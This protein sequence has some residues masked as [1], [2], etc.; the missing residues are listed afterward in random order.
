MAHELKKK[1]EKFELNFNS[2]ESQAHELKFKIF[3]LE[4]ELL[5]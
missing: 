4:L 2:V 5:S 1:I 3:K